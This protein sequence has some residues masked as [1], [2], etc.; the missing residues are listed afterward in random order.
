MSD[1]P[2][3]E[4]LAP[5]QPEEVMTREWLITDN[6]ARRLYSEML[7]TGQKRTS[8]N[9]KLAEDGPTPPK[10]KTSAPKP[11]T[12][13]DA[14]T[15][16]SKAW[17]E[18]QQAGLAK[19]PI[20]IIVALALVGVVYGAYVHMQR[21]QAVPRSRMKATSKIG[22]MSTPTAATADSAVRQQAISLSPTLS[23]ITS[24]PGQSA[25]Q[26]LTLVNDTPNELSFEVVVKDLVVRDGKAVFLP[27]GSA[28]N[29]VAATAVFAE[30]YFNIKPQQTKI[31]SIEFTV[32]PQT[33][34]RG[35]LVMLQGTDKLAFGK[36]T[37]T[38]NLGAVIT[39]DVP[40]STAAGLDGAGASAG[41]ASFALSQ[42]AADAA[43]SSLATQQA[44]LGAGGGDT[45]RRQDSNSGLGLGG[46][47]P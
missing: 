9:A 15:P 13:P 36:A 23:A 35:I 45:P 26:A 11:A 24:E 33:T 4:Q 16:Q 18:E 6:D 46:Q 34:S 39:I 19:F 3:V 5:P 44:P 28:L 32:H 12:S 21:S 30:K 22:Q 8:A 42:W 37:M 29:G 47:Q 27:P 7:G 14:L 40:E 17:G 20:R 31:I 41:A 38:A 25:K 43:S 2:K 1:Q 10:P